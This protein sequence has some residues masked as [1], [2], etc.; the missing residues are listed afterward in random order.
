MKLCFETT[1]GFPNHTYFLSD[2]MR[3]M[4]GYIKQGSEKLLMMS[5]PC[6]FDP[7]GRELKRIDDNK[8]SNTKTA[9]RAN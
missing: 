3:T 1:P 8:T 9:E 7:R 4:Y 5:K 6:P 2:D